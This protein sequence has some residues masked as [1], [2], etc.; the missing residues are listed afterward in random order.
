VLHETQGK[1]KIIFTFFFLQRKMKRFMKPFSELRANF[2]C[3]KKFCRNHP[4]KI[5]EGAEDGGEIQVASLP[6]S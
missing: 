4:T 2:F 5:D 6:M 1:K 3:R